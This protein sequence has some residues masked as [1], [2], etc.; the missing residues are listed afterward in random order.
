LADILVLTGFMGVGK[1]ATGRALAEMRGWDFVD[2]DEAVEAAAGKSV[3][4]IFAEDGEARFREL[5]SRELRR[6][7]GRARLVVAAGG[8]LLL[9]E[10]NRELLRDALVVNLDAP[11]EECLRRVRTSATTRPLLAGPDPERRARELYEARRGLYEAVS[12]RVDTAGKTPREVAREIA[13]TVLAG[14]SP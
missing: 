6:V 7:L 8:G 9:R 4:R 12:H 1:T 10:A 13:E 2:L 14:D 3:E 11:L 5:E